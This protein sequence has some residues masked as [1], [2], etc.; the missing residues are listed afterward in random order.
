MA[1]RI[2][3][4]M[5]LI[6]WWVT[7]FFI[8]TSTPAPGTQRCRA[9]ASWRPWGAL[10]G[11]NGV[12]A[13]SLGLPDEEFFIS[14]CMCHPQHQLGPYFSWFLHIPGYRT[15]KR[16]GNHRNFPVFRT[17][18]PGNPKNGPKTNGISGSRDFLMKAPYL[19]AVEGVISLGTAPEIN[20]WMEL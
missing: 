9:C 5:G 13:D 2:S 7:L 17:L 19:E 16:P 4:M 12:S 6:H 10:T 8:W 20:T 15:W 18:F 14:W 11:A 3:H 1:H